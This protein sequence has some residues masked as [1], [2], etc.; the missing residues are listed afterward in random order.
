M[1]EH[2]VVVGAERQVN[3]NERLRKKVEATVGVDAD[4]A[5]KGAGLSAAEQAAEA[6]RHKAQAKARAKLE[7]KAKKAAARKKKKKGGGGGGAD[8]EEATET[9]AVLLGSGAGN[10]SDP[11]VAGSAD[12]EAL[13]GAFAKAQDEVLRL[14]DANAFSGFLKYAVTA[15]ISEARVDVAVQDDG[16]LGPA[17]RRHPGDAHP[18]RV[19]RHHCRPL[20][21]QR[22]HR[23][24]LLRV[25]LLLQRQGAAMSQHGFAG[26]YL[27][28]ERKAYRRCKAV[29]RAA[30]GY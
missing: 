25:Q 6:K 5:A 30:P 27:R 21:A 1:A 4:A 20:V 9:L 29:W 11:L 2:F 8:D 28:A 23:P 7:A 18:A 14:M 19:L 15:N 10:S 26:R 12:E 3:I 24:D 22:R 16:A 17:R 13:K